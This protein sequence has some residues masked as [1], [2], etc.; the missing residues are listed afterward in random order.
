MTTERAV[1]GVAMRHV[2]SLRDRAAHAT[3][4]GSFN[5]SAR[6]VV[7]RTGWLAMYVLGRSRVG[8]L[9]ADAVVTTVP[10]DLRRLSEKARR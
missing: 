8:I 9:A 3:K 5:A 7:R 6:E 1:A 10:S 2:A 4:E